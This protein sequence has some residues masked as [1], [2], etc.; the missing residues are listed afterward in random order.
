[1]I[2]E[3][4]G[5]CYHLHCF[6]VRL[7]QTACNALLGERMASLSAGCGPATNKLGAASVGLHCPR[8]H[9]WPPPLL[10]P[11]TLALEAPCASYLQPKSL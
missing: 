4:L 9:K 5:L 2:I 7:S 11:H 6:K 1:M 3:S 10:P 8:N